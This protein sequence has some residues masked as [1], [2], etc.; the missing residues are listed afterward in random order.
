[1]ATDQQRTLDV[2]L[3]TINSNISPETVTRDY[4]LSRVY[5]V[6]KPECPFSRFFQAKVHYILENWSQAEKFAT[7]AIGILESTDPKTGFPRD[8]LRDSYYCR[9]RAQLFQGRTKEFEE[10]VRTLEEK[11]A[12]FRK[13]LEP[14]QTMSKKIAI[15]L[16]KYVIVL[17]KA[18]F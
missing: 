10:T 16:E 13:T 6:L 2:L 11:G 18:G 1:M 7:E 5:S 8:I 3:K 17:I 14:L 12:E 15:E 4:M 9:G